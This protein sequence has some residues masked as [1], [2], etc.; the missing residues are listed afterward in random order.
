MYLFVAMSVLE[1]S[2]ATL[3]SGSIQRD[4]SMILKW[5]KY[6]IQNHKT[7]QMVQKS[8]ATWLDKKLLQNSK[9]K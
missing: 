3:A 1:D 5:V 7:K 9:V 4:G 8:E 6:E 2:A